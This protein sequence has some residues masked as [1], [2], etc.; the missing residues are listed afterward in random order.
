MWRKPTPLQLRLLQAVAVGLQGI[1]L[2]L[3]LRNLEKAIQ[4]TFKIV[5]EVRHVPA[6]G[7]S[8]NFAGHTEPHESNEDKTQHSW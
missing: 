6:D 1:Q 2:L 8:G 3:R 4:Q 5:I 7:S